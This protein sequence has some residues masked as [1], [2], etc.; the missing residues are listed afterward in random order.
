VR[1]FSV[2]VGLHLES[3]F[4][5]ILVFGV[6]CSFVSTDEKPPLLL[7]FGRRSW[8]RPDAPVVDATFAS[9][10]RVRDRYA[11]RYGLTLAQ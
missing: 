11:S 9:V 3:E 1:T 2:L 5:F 8:E 4:C 6:W 7:D 10:S